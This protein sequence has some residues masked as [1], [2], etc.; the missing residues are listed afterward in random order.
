MTKFAKNLYFE[1]NTKRY[2]IS[3]LLCT[4]SFLI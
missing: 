3:L 1:N 4:I 2:H